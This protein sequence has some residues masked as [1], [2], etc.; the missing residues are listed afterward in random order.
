MDRAAA[1][2]TRA[3]IF[4]AKGNRFRLLHSRDGWINE[5]LIYTHGY[6]LTMNP[7]NGFT[8]EGLPQLVLGNMPVQSTIAEITVK[9]PEIYFGELTN[10]DVYVKTRQKEFNYPQGQSNSLTSYE[11][12]GGIAIGGFVRH[13]PHELEELRR[14]HD[15]IRDRRVLDQLLRHPIPMS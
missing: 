7:V 3:I 13:P 14:M 8:P 11:G 12:S 10:T 4:T 5:R 15:R 2:S 9:R 6:G 1:R